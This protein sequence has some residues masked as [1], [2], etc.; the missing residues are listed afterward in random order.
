MGNFVQASHVFLNTPAATRQEA[1]EFLSA[2][3]VEVGLANDAA[4]V[5]DAFVAR[6]ALESTG[7]LEGFAIPHAKSEAITDAAVFIAK[8]AAPID[9]WKTMDGSS[10]QVA[11]ALLV[12][13][14]EAGTTHLQLLSKTAVLL[15]DAE[16]RTFVTG[17]EDAEAIAER[18]NAGLTDAN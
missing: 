4:A 2:K 6:E 17:S 5:L 10:V 15:M 13:D 1:L 12:P 3:A 8:F 7:M 16:F 14:G 18:V 11:I 9:D